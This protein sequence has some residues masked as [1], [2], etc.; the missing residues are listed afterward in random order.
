[1]G[2]VSCEEQTLSWTAGQNRDEP[3][4]FFSQART[5][6]DLTGCTVSLVVM[7]SYSSTEP[8]RVFSQSDHTSAAAGET[9]LPVDLSDVPDSWRV[10]GK[11]LV[12]SLWVVDAANKV[13]PWGNFIIQISPAAPLPS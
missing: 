7:E 2:G 9:T 13:N 3:L 6:I 12:A 5:P 10:S 1:M 11:R 4:A 8:W